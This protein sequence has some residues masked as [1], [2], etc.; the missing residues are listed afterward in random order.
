MT[1]SKFENICNIL[2]S[3]IT[4][5][6]SQY[7]KIITFA[8]AAFLLIA[9][10]VMQK[11]LTKSSAESSHLA[12]KKNFETWVAKAQIDDKALSTLKGHL[13]KLPE[14][15]PL[16][17]WKI[18][19]Q[20]LTVK[21]VHTAKS[22]LKD[23]NFFQNHADS[24]YFHKFSEISILITAKEYLKAYEESLLLKQDLLADTS[25][26]EKQGYA[27]YG[28]DLFAYNLV[29]IAFL[30][31]FVGKKE[32]ELSAWAEIKKYSQIERDVTSSHCLIDPA[33]CHKLFM[34]FSEDGVSL[35]D[36][37]KYRESY[38]QTT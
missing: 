15:T 35:S 23:T 14:L 32:L 28:S 36:Y 7:K 37:I 5:S 31:K 2:L 17:Q 26:W 6:Q 18:I 21:D 4:S 24:V 19:Q 8:A 25:F 3:K 34:L 10:F 38:L 20:C 30:S 9:G 22:L 27:K 33:A 1:N 12:F 13:K 29:R 16:Y 11:G